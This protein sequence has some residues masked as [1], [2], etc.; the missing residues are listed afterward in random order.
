MSPSQFV[1]EI[2]GEL[3]TIARNFRWL[4]GSGCSRP[5]R[6]RATAF[7]DRRDHLP[8]TVVEEFED[9][10]RHLGGEGAGDTQGGFCGRVGGPQPVAI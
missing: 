3:S 7:V 1:E 5:G 2:G 8:T 4:A 6:S 10:G 9:V